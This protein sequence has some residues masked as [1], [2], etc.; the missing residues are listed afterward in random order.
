MLTITTVQSSTPSGAGKVT[1]KAMGKQRT[2]RVSHDRTPEANAASAVGALLDALL[3]SRQQAKILHPS[4]GL[5]H[6]RLTRRGS[7]KLLAGNPP[8]SY[9]RVTCPYSEI[10]PPTVGALCFN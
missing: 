3:D 5:V 8:G 9:S 4:G 1:A 6:Q 7:R 10:R 2:V